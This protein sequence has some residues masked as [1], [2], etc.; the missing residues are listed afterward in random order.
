M[1]GEKEKEEKRKGGRDRESERKRERER[2]RGLGRRERGLESPNQNRDP[3][4]QN[5]IVDPILFFADF[6]LKP[7]NG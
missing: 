3:L 5:E 7:V 1:E 4:F 6:K 2:K